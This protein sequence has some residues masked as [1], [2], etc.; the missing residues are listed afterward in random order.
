MFHE[1]HAHLETANPQP[2]M[3]P[4]KCNVSTQ[5]SGTSGDICANHL[6]ALNDRDQEAFYLS[7]T[8]DLL[9][10]CV[11]WWECLPQQERDFLCVYTTMNASPD[12][13]SS[14]SRIFGLLCSFFR[15]RL[16]L[17]LPP[18]SPSPDDPEV[19]PE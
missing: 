16:F 12:M 8:K 5:T 15:Q 17:V 3:W 11:R 19:L 2:A 18:S 7:S 9:G 1:Q 4:E 14:R 6:G 13:T 10:H